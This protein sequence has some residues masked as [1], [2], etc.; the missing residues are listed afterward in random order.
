MW[1]GNPVFPVD[2]L[3]VLAPGQAIYAPVLEALKHQG[4][5]TIEHHVV[6]GPRLPGE[7]R[8]AAIARARNQAKGVGQAHYVLFLDRDVI[9][10]PHGIEALVLGLILDPRYA[11]VGINYQE[12]VPPGTPH[13]AMG[14]VLFIRPILEQIHFRAE[15]DTCECCSC[16]EDIRRMGY[17]I[18]YLPGLRARH[19]RGPLEGLQRER[20]GQ[21]RHRFGRGAPHSLSER[22]KEGA[23]FASFWRARHAARGPDEADA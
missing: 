20:A 5:V 13:V 17:R 8:V 21:E 23:R 3:T 12:P 14:A 16:C 6:E 11:A 22:F 2:V 18:D 19:L 9:L 10:P 15:P 7:P 4:H 1:S